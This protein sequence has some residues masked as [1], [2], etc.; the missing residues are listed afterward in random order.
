MDDKDVIT[1]ESLPNF[2]QAGGPRLYT[3]SGRKVRDGLLYRSSRTDFVTEKDLQELRRLGIRTILDLRP[4]QDYKRDLA[5]GD[6]LVNRSFKPYIVKTGQV[7]DLQHTDTTWKDRLKLRKTQKCDDT[8]AVE[9]KGRLDENEYAKEKRFI[10]NLWTKD[11]ILHVFQKLN[12][13]VRFLS[14]TL[15]L[16][17][18][19]LG[20]HIF[21]KFYAWAVVNK[22]EL[23][24]SYLDILEHSKGPVVDAIRVIADSRN[25]PVLVHCAHGK[26]RT[27]VII[28]LVLGALGVEEGTIVEDY[29]KS[30]VGTYVAGVGGVAPSPPVCYACLYWWIVKSFIH[31]C[32]I[33]GTGMVC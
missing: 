24:E 26:D 21:V 6:G 2:R 10:V 7:H 20:S 4:K 5:Q 23:W 17:D 16:V 14:L 30:E 32:F 11:L 8:G 12:F 9:R 1:L 15:A 13:F 33:T 25:L 29:A 3:E 18:W 27:G 31:L 22:V 28:A 19:I